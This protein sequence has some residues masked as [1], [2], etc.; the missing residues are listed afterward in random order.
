[1]FNA[2]I[3]RFCLVCGVAPVSRHSPNARLCDGCALDALFKAMAEPFRCP[4]CE[5]IQVLP[6]HERFACPVCGYV[7]EVDD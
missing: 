5:T 7:E 6:E 1:M 4:K 2:L 3:A